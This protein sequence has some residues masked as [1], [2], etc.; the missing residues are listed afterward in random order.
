[1]SQRIYIYTC[2][3]HGHVPDSAERE[4]SSRARIREVSMRLFRS[5]FGGRAPDRRCWHKDGQMA[6]CYDRRGNS[7]FVEQYNS[8]DPEV[9]R[10]AEE[11]R[12][13]ESKRWWLA[14]AP[15]H[16]RTAA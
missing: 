9:I 1:M 2:Y 6:A 7:I 12:K 15:A 10:Q 8:G 5:W 3:R 4:C 11:A 16:G 14:I 13:R